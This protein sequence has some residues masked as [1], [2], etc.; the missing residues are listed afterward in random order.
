MM[1]LTPQVAL[2]VAAMTVGVGDLIFI[3]VSG[4]VGWGWILL[5]VTAVTIW[6]S[7]DAFHRRRD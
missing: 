6:S 5:V 4:D 3:L 2:T 1:R 7:S